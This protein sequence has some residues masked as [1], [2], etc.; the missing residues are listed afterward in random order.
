MNYTITRLFVTKPYACI[1]NRVFSN[2]KSFTNCVRQ[3][4]ILPNTDLNLCGLYRLG[5]L[6]TSYDAGR[7]S[8]QIVYT[9]IRF[10]S[11]KKNRRL[12]RNDSDE[13]DEEE[14]DD[15]QSKLDEFRHGDKTSD[16]NLTEIKVQTLRLDTVIKSGLGF[17]KK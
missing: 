12:N 14:S 8:N 4:H 1:L 10:K 17:S 5:A 13:E 16:R 15:E 11:N 3:L 2:P 7:S 6:Q 9:T